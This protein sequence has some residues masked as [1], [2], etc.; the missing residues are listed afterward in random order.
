MYIEK[1]TIEGFKSYAQRTVIEGFDPTFNAITGLNGSG[2]SNIL[3]SICFV[4]GISNLSQVR[5]DS[6]Q[7]L[8]YKKGQSGITKASVTI[9]FNNT[10]KEASP[11]GYTEH[12][13]IIVTRQIAIGGRNKYLINGSPA[14]LNRVQ[15]LFH[16]VQLNVNNP[17]FLIMQG[18][19]TKVLN[20]KPP[21]ILS[22][23][24]EAAG[25]RMF[26]T[27]KKSSLA[28]IEKK[29]KKVDEIKKILDEEITPL[30]ENLKLE[31]QD[32]MKWTNYQTQLENLARFITAYE[33]Y[34]AVN[35][36]SNQAN[37]L[38]NLSN[39][40]ES[41][42]AKKQENDAE[43]KKCEQ[44]LK[45]MEK[46]GKE[47]Q[48]ISLLEQQEQELSNTIIKYSSNVKNLKESLDKEEKIL[49]NVCSNRQE[50]KNTI[51]TKK[52]EKEQLEK[53]IAGIVN[54]NNQL[55]A[56]LKSLQNKLQALTTGIAAKGDSENASYTEQLMEAKREAVNA[57]SNIKQ[58]EIR[59]KHLNN[60]LVTKKRQATLE[61]SD[62]KSMTAEFN[63]VEKDL[64]KLKE[65]LANLKFDESLESQ[66]IKEKKELEPVVSQLREKVGYMSSRL[67]G[68][69]FTY[70]DPTKNF[71]RQKV[72]G[73][74]ANLIS[75][76][77]ADA[78]TALE[79]CAGG[80]L[81]NIIIDDDETGKALLAKGQLKRKVTLLPLNKIDGRALSNSVVD[82]AKKVSKNNAK[83]AIDYVDF[84]P[85][86]K[87]AMNYVFGNTFIA[88]DKQSARTVAFDK[89][90][91]TKTI[92]LEGDEYNPQ[93]S[94]TGGSAPNSGSL[95]KQIQQLNDASKQLNEKQKD[96]EKVNYG[97]ANMKSKSDQYKTLVQKIQIKEHE[98]TLVHSR[99]KLNPHQQLIESI[100]E[101][102]KAIQ[103]DTQLV[104]TSKIKEKEH[105][106]KVKELE[107][108][109]NNF[110]AMRE[111]QLKET[112]KN[113]ATLKEK[114]NK[115]N[116]VVK[117]EQVSIEKIDIE[118]DELQN[119]L[120]NLSNETQ[121]KM[122]QSIEKYKKEIKRVEQL[123]DETKDQ[124]SDVKSALSEKL[125]I[126]RNENE[127][128][129]KLLTEIDTLTAD[130]RDLDIQA[131]Q[132]ENKIKRF[133]KDTQDATRQVESFDKKYSWIKS[134]KKLFGVPHG[135][136]DFVAKDPIK[137][138]QEYNKIKEEV[139][140]L[141]KT[142]N[143]KVNSMFERTEEDFRQLINK[144]EII[145]NDKKKIEEAIQQLDEKKNKSLRDTW[146]KVNHDFGSIFSTLLPGTKAK[147][148]PPKGQ[149]EL[150]GLEVKVAFGDVWK[151]SL[152]ELSGGQ[153]SLLA[154][155][156][157][158]S[159]LLFKPAPMYIL[160]EI[161]AALDLSHTQNI[162][163]MLKQHF[164]HSQ[165]IVV[166]LKEGMF[167]NANVLFE[168]K[169]VDGVSKV[170]RTEQKKKS[171]K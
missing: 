78:S 87:P 57:A 111:K 74:V 95:L 134:E 69:E 64:N 17:H 33:Y 124:E 84:D 46:R 144:K 153:K 96:L 129:Q 117:A 113:I 86:L 162:G 6:L 32:Y 123:I 149:T 52:Q 28:T 38:S 39:E 59:I 25:T 125:R 118:I 112:E 147:L 75:L 101:I 4:L 165:F 91:H 133:N 103:D 51:D 35:L 102:E 70:T 14:Q 108:C 5:A 29:Q 158:L 131:Q 92:S 93:G 43:R 100:A 166:S 67:S 66:L 154:L 55:N 50:I 68:I 61:A 168:T 161:D 16:S 137:K 8:V 170:S 160:D 54:E 22:M 21:E 81:Y 40:L 135:E 36:L 126:S 99:L 1:I 45:A 109:S 90:V 128:S 138:N 150:D 44:Q 65:D 89:N 164:Q 47:L 94:L 26:E 7:D 37:E 143:K 12:D 105:L 88:T 148:E 2:K 169:F 152:S 127:V 11:V 23:I 19:I 53:K 85:T 10:N 48:E 20:M 145:E 58:A 110:E 142:V 122:E 140:R 79:I 18:R 56:D 167:N 121:I 104:E 30:L 62:H 146:K 82:A 27:K 41:K 116:K 156:L 80:K 3:D 114:C 72:K 120:N 13:S 107:G 151:E 31:R 115:S 157:I 73:V 155:S 136:Y 63:L 159:L 24:E 15:N 171:K 141:D 34:K 60:E 139:E 130:N 119:E 97:I 132:L 77:D 71:D 49:G 9:T 42:R 98:S 106:D 163:L 76:R 83:P